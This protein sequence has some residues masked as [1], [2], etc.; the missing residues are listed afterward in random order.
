M[1]ASAR[2]ENPVEAVPAVHLLPRG[3]PTIDDA[4][5]AIAALMARVEAVE[6]STRTLADALLEL[7]RSV[8]D[9]N[10]SAR[11]YTPLRQ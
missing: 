4:S 1:T 5:P 7:R 11:Y 3:E 8:R 10:R 6:A 2:D 9:L